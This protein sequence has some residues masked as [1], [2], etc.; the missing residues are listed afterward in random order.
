[1]HD[2]QF[3]IRRYLDID[4]HH[5]DSDLNRLLDCRQ[6]ILGG[7]AGAGGT[8]VGYSNG[9]NHRSKTSSYAPNFAR[10]P[11]CA[12]AKAIREVELMW[13]RLPTAHPRSE[14]A[15]A[16]TGKTR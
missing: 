10:R 4:L 2:H 12:R 16:G 1:M 14:N 3:A 5:V 7:E 11:A 15:T 9:R 6:R 8:A 13:P